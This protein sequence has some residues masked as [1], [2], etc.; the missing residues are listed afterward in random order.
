MTIKEYEI[1]L[2]AVCAWREARS[3]GLTG[4][5]MV[6]AVMA[7]RAHNGGFGDWI[8][9]ITKRGQ[10]S[11]MSI[12]GDSQLVLWPLN[13][14]TFRLLLIDAEK[15]RNGSEVDPTNGAL[16]YENPKVAT[17]KWF[18]DNIRGNPVDHPIVA[19]TEHHVFYK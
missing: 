8:T 17:S 18:I 1:A 7:N 9:V 14:D 15:F 19:R 13:T 12:A 10:F 6:L 3:E 11:S 16:Y 5:R 4:M 2:A